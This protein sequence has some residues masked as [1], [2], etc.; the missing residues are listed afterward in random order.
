MGG[1][2]RPA[3]LP[4]GL[5]RRAQAGGASSSGACSARAAVP[6]ARP[7]PCGSGQPAVERIGPPALEPTVP[8]RITP[9]LRGLT[10]PAVDV[11]GDVGRVAR[12][13]RGQLRR[14]VCRVPNPHQVIAASDACSGGGKL[15]GIDANPLL[16]HEGAL[17][18][19][20]GDL[21]CHDFFDAQVICSP[22][23]AASVFCELASIWMA[24]AL[25][26]VLANAHPLAPTSFNTKTL[27][28]GTPSEST[29]ER[30]IA[31]GSAT[32][33]WRA[34]SNQSRNR[35]TRIVRHVIKV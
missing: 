6:S 29:V 5:S 9:E 12:I 25:V 17:R 13:E 31:C 3:R 21:R 14:I 24:L 7:R 2:R 4:A 33:R 30:V 11:G 32:S 23:F 28:S 34:S 27:A 18:V 19:L 26:R 15:R 35:A 20:L 22:H 10:Q 1:H 16:G 8:L